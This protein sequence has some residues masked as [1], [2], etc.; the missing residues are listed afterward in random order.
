VE[1]IVAQGHEAAAVKPPAP[2]V[3]SCVT[4]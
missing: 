2:S 4:S 3:A 1:R